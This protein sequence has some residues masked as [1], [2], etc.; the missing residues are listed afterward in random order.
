MIHSGLEFKCDFND[1]SAEF[2][3]ALDLRRHKN[4]HK[5]TYSCDYKGCSYSAISRF[6]LD[7]HKSQPTE[8]S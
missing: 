7:L 4:K 8:L 5:V 6:N 1:C 3:Y 2:V